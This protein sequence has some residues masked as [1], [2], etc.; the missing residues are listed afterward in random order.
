MSVST[1]PVPKVEKSPLAIQCDN[2]DLHEKSFPYPPDKEAPD[3]PE[4]M[5]PAMSPTEA[6]TLT[7]HANARMSACP[8][9]H[10][11][12]GK[13]RSMKGKQRSKKVK[14][15]DEEKKRKSSSSPSKRATDDRE[16]ESEDEIFIPILSVQC[17]KCRKWRRLSEGTD[18][19]Q[20]PDKWYCHMN[21]GKR[22]QTIGKTT[23]DRQTGI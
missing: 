19:S 8:T 15:G 5:G 13:K 22:L 3:T 4:S 1:A 2:S 11:L 6:K 7:G 20:L 12:N 10:M 17:E 18:P 21:P 23:D 9:N 14:S 16:L